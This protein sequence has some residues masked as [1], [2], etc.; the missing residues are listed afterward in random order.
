MPNEFLKKFLAGTARGI[1]DRN[2]GRWEK[3]ILIV[4]LDELLKDFLKIFFKNS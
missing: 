4:S 3:K 2:Y 1:L